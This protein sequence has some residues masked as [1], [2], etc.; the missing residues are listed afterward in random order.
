MQ[1]NQALL[2][3]LDLLL[4]ECWDT[5]GA[6]EVLLSHLP[7]TDLRSVLREASPARG[8]VIKLFDTLSNYNHTLQNNPKPPQSGTEYNICHC[9]RILI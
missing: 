2:L 3:L 9:F 4:Q 8:C 1:I 5:P 7:Q 6:L